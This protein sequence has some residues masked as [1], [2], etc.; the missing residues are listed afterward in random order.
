MALTKQAFL[1]RWKSAAAGAAISAAALLSPLSGAYGQSAT[2]TQV[3]AQPSAYSTK[4]VTHNVPI[5]RDADRS[6]DQW[7][8]GH[9][10][11][12]AISV[13][14]G[15]GTQ[16]PSEHVAKVLRQDFAAQGVTDIAFYFEKGT[17]QGD[18]TIAVHTD[19]YV[20]GPYALQDARKPIQEIASQFRFNQQ[21]AAMTGPN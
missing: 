3:T 17:S 11:R 6:A 10:D 4:N 2:Q 12:M 21:M 16:V 18:T 20:W 13:R 15:Q 19:E 8:V 7:V 1:G 14:I 9:D 5:S